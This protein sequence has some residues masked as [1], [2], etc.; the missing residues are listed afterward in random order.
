MTKKIL[1]IL[2]MIK[3]SHSVFALP[4]ALA[5]MV[6]AAKGWPPSQTVALIVAAMVTARSAAM[7]FNRIVDAEIDAKNPRTKNRH[8]PQNII[9][10]K[11]ASIFTFVSVLLFFIVCHQINRLSFILSPVAMVILLGYSFSKRFTW[12]S[13]FWLGTSL[14]IA[15]IAAWIAVTGTVSMT[16]IWLGMAVLFWVTGFDILYATQDYDFDREHGVHSLVARFGI[17]KSLNI[18]KLCHIVT[19]LLLL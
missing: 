9:S 5:A 19:L 6:V 16:P 13:Q 8:I 15:P 7:A 1:I 18:A 10:K 17:K 12:A 11:F 4:F 14:G 2:E 3:F